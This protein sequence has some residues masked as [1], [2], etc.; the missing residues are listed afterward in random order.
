MMGALFC[1]ALGVVLSRAMLGALGVLG[2]LF[3][4]RGGVLG[5]EGAKKIAIKAQ[6]HKGERDSQ[7]QTKIIVFH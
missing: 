7:D 4:C 6:E 1:G 5:L 2:A 3:A